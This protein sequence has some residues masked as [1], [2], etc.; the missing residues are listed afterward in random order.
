[1]A[2]DDSDPLAATATAAPTSPAGPPTSRPKSIGRYL[3]TG[4]LG[5]G[6]MGV[7]F[8]AHDPDL[9]RRIALKVLRG[10]GSDAARARLLREARAMAKLSHPA[11]VVVHEVGS[12]DGVDYVAMELIDGTT[13]GDWIATAKPTPADVLEAYEAAGR[14]LA[15]AHA[16]GLVHRDFKP[17]NVLRARSGRVVVTDFGLARAALDLDETLPADGAG[18]VIAAAA[19]ANTAG[20]LS[21]TLT[22]TG[23]VLGTPA[24]M[25]PEQHAGAAVGPAADQFAY[26]VALWESLAGAR[27]FQGETMA[28][29]RAAMDRGPDRTGEAKIPRDLRAPLRRGLAVRPVDRFGG[30]PEL[31]A[32]IHGRRN[33]TRFVRRLLLAGVVLAAMIALALKMRPPPPA[34]PDAPAHPA[35]VAGCGDPAT[36]LAGVEPAGLRA[37]LAGAPAGARIGQFLDA[38]ATE[39]R[40]AQRAICAATGDPD[41]AR[42]VQCL[43]G[44]R[45]DLHRTAAA[46]DT[47]DVDE[48]AGA[49]PGFAVG[50]P[51]ACQAMP[52]A[53][54][55]VVYDDA[56]SIAIAAGALGRPARRAALPEPPASTPCQRATYFMS[57]LHDFQTL[58]FA[59]MVAAKTAAADAA[60]RCNDDHVIADVTTLVASTN[61]NLVYQD[62]AIAARMHAAV[63]RAGDD[64]TLA[65]LRDL[66][67]GL[68]ATYRHDLDTAIEH[69]YAS[70][71]AATTRGAWSAGAYVAETAAD[72]MVARRH[73]HDLDGAEKLLRGAIATAGPSVQAQVSVELF[74]VLFYE[75][76]QGEALQLALTTPH[77]VE[78]A[79]PHGTLV[80]GRVVDD[81]GAPVEGARV[82]ADDNITV[83]GG[84]LDPF[85]GTELV[86]TS[87]HDGSFAIATASPTAW[88]MA[89]HDA[90]ASVPVHA[91][92]N[93]ELHL[94]AT[95]ELSGRAIATTPNLGAITVHV[96]FDDSV[97]H[98]SFTG[99]VA[100]DGSWRVTG[101]PLGPV[102]LDL[103][104]GFGKHKRL[105]AT[106]AAT[107]G[108]PITTELAV[109]GHAIDVIVRD[110]VDVPVTV[111]SVWVV[112][113]K[114]VPGKLVSDLERVHADIAKSQALAVPLDVAPAAVH[115]ALR[116]GDALTHFAAIEPGD[117]QVC[118]IGAS[119]DFTDAAVQQRWMTHASEMPL[120]CVPVHVA[121]ADQV[122]VVEV[123]PMKR[124]E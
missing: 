77:P 11:V 21:S 76:K 8:A 74:R 1:V 100:D 79:R 80:R 6:G 73:P 119:G 48:L 106:V 91:G 27:P 96:A 109:S 49:D 42:R 47:L 52:H 9:D 30:M 67:D 61:L 37:R 105:T 54:E 29:V 112:R 66:V 46:L 99:P 98:V 5:Q 71:E 35:A 104:Y 64:R 122:V 114:A 3:I 62:P 40:D 113:G 7:V 20:S 83:Y 55:R 38:R 70:A 72:M 59:D 65:A 22:A 78:P 25:A 124:F 2:A 50:D 121:D 60:D 43:L 97:D 16:A 4:E 53:P 68:Q 86:A 24:Y 23:A 33:Q 18:A 90:R 26:C 31:L 118:A 94:R 34:P 101:V 102:R 75:G 45:A 57:K 111:G 58:P 103:G 44:V 19:G 107:P 87:A 36:E 13:L 17:H 82:I 123:P 89:T 10:G 15:A 85:E 110:Q 84:A 117:V 12:A 81:R 14:G 115:G 92:A 51:A 108:A 28:D 56:A 39:W 32:A 63:A 120:T 88:V 116:S 41:H 95:G 69:L 93:L